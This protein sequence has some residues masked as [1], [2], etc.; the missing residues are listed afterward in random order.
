MKNEKLQSAK[1]DYPRGLSEPF[2]AAKR[3]RKA[4]T[5]S[6]EGCL[7]SSGHAAGAVSQESMSRLWG[8]LWLRPAPHPALTGCTEQF[9]R[10]LKFTKFSIS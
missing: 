10:T 7:R 1:H 4:E 9:C 5:V 8:G 6:G 2:G 3:E